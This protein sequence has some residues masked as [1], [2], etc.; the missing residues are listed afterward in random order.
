MWG[1]RADTTTTVTT[2]AGAAD[3]VFLVRARNLSSFRV[4]PRTCV[5]SSAPEFVNDDSAAGAPLFPLRRE[6][7][8]LLSFKNNP[9]SQ[10]LPPD[11]LLLLLRSSS[12]AVIRIRRATP[13][14]SAAP[15]P[16]Q[17]RY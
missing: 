5:S 7:A 4:L 14:R 13:P 17:N 11:H 1:V 15:P 2:V 16:Q 12:A 8:S 6:E 10:H 9:S 3:I